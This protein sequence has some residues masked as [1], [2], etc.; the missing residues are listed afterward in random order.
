VGGAGVTA[1]DDSHDLDALRGRLIAVRNG[2]AAL[3]LSDDRHSG[4]ADPSTGE[5]WHRGNVL[6]HVN[7]MLPYWT[8]QLQRAIAG[9][10]KVGRDQEGAAQRRQGIEHGDAASEEQLRLAVD[11]GIEGVVELLA[12]MTPE[13]LERVVVYHNRDGDRDARV[14]EL[15]QFLM[16]GHLEDHLAQLTGLDSQP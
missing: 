3:P 5:S 11:E 4:P 10:G 16:V 12:L 13:D 15:V 14:G 2:Y 8:G 6:G 9:S 1:R 7:E